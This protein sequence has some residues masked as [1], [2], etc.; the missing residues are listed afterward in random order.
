MRVVCV[1]SGTGSAK[2]MADVANK[3]DTIVAGRLGFITWLP[4]GV[5]G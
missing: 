2:L 3:T 5:G 1:S 4:V